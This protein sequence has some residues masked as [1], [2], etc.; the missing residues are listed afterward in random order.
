MRNVVGRR[1]TK[2]VRDRAAK[3]Q[4]VFHVRQAREAVAMARAM[5]AMGRP[6]E[7]VARMVF[8]AQEHRVA[9]RQWV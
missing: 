4:F 9:A 5:V 6:P 7:S 8:R 1:P 2:E 3:S